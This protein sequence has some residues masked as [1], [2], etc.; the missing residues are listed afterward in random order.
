MPFP[1]TPGSSEAL[2]SDD[3]KSVVEPG[4]SVEDVVGADDDSRCFNEE[5]VL[6]ATGTELG[7]EKLED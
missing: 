7:E 3:G 2:L 4:E 1:L 5:T 6:A